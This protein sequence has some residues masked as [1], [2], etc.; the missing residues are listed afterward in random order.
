[1]LS[2]ELLAAFHIGSRLGRLANRLLGVA[3]L[4]FQPEV[5]RLDTEG[6]EGRVVQSTWIFLKFQSVFAM[7]MAAVLVVFAREMIVLVSSPAYTKAVPLLVLFALSLPLTTMTAPITTVMKAVDQVRGALWCDLAWAACYVALILTLG[8]PLGLI[9]VGVAQLAA[10]AIQLVFA[11]RLSRMPIGGIRLWRLAAK[12]VLIG[13]I[14]FAPAVV[15]E[16]IVDSTAL[17]MLGVKMVL[18]AAGVVAFRYLVI[19]VKVFG[20]HERR[21]LD[22]MLE[23]RRLQAVGRLIGV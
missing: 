5:T 18:F 13:G 20:D 12:L 9:G 6:R 2:L 3:N 1:V 22:A 21:S 14:A 10:C 11:M 4:A 17:T 23:S 19:A 7:L 16:M 15:C 8:P